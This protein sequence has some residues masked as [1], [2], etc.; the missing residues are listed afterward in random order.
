MCIMP[1][2]ILKILNV[3]TWPLHQ[4]TFKMQHSSKFRGRQ[5][6]NIEAVQASNAQPAAVSAEAHTFQHS[7]SLILFQLMS[8]KIMEEKVLERQTMQTNGCW[9]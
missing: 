6:H 5:I 1:S 4:P 9:F 8:E 7:E 3:Q 2:V